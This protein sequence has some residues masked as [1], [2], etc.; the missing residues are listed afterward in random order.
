MS[1][2]SGA[3]TNYMIGEIETLLRIEKSKGAWSAFRHDPVHIR[4]HKHHI[5]VLAAQ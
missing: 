4:K 1:S 5:A 3:D 2:M